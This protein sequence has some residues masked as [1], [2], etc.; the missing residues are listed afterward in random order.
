V[1]KAALSRVQNKLELADQEPAPAQP[2]VAEM[3]Q[4]AMSAMTDKNK[5]PEKVILF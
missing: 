4:T 2:N 1:Q 3:M 5:K